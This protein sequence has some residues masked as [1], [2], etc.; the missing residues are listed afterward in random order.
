MEPHLGWAHQLDARQLLL[1]F[2][3]YFL[4]VV[5]LCTGSDGSVHLVPGAREGRGK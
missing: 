2:H 1:V 3:N 4:Q 5:Q